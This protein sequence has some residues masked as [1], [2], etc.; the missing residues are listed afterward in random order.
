MS[1][2][3][4]RPNNSVKSTERV[5][6]N[7]GSNSLAEVHLEKMAI[8]TVCVCVCVNRSYCRHCSYNTHLSTLDFPWN[9]VSHVVIVIKTI[10]PGSGIMLYWY[11][12]NSRSKW[13]ILCLNTRQWWEATVLSLHTHHRRMVCYCPQ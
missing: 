11:I 5:K 10:I 4:C 9:V 3:S 1:Y 6:E 12:M 2:M 7:Q 8:K 13:E